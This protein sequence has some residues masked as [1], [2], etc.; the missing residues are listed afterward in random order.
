MDLLF[1]ISFLYLV[2]SS[3]IPHTIHYQP[4]SIPFRSICSLVLLIN[5]TTLESSSINYNFILTSYYPSNGCFTQKL[6]IPDYY[7]VI[8]YFIIL[9]MFHFYLGTYITG[10]CN[11]PCFELQ[12]ISALG[13][14]ILLRQ[15]WTI[16]QK[17]P[18]SLETPVAPKAIAKL[19]QV[20]V[21]VSP[22]RSWILW[23]RHN[24]MFPFAILLDKVQAVSAWGFVGAVVVPFTI[25]QSPVLWRYAHIW[26][27]HSL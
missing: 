24:S 15:N 22:T 16:D 18:K 12:L 3:I 10:V 4:L 23:E 26:A 14:C 17:S 25:N 19:I 7:I 2:S 20:L 8:S 13:C 6:S 9:Y 1:V 21:L 5:I 11:T 27:D